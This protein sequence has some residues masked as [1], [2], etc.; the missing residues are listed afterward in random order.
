M[1]RLAMMA[2]LTVM[3]SA[4]T[5]QRPT[6]VLQAGLGD[7]HESWSAVSA[8]I[9]AQAQVFAYDRPGYGGRAPEQGPRDPCTIA[10]ELRQ[11]L[12]HSGL[13]PPYIL[14]GHSFGGLYQYVFAKL[15]PKDVAGILLVDPT[16]PDHWRRMQH[17]APATAA[18]MK[19]MRAVAFSDVMRAEFDDQARC[20]EHIDT[21]QPLTIPAR[22]LVRTQFGFMESTAFAKM[23]G[24]L[25]S[26]WQ[27]L[28]GVSAAQHVR[29]AGHYIHHDRPD[30]VVAALR[31]V[32]GEVRAHGNECV[33]TPSRSRSCSVGRKASRRVRSL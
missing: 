33:S 8:V 4:A 3:T 13:A 9:A 22:L 24:S 29:G 26:D 31:A 6:V 30:D 16:H 12:R 10:A 15:Y 7:G 1:P 27:R 11:A 28:L 25:A 20:L 17:D 21:Q 2:L 23:T 14:V 19:V 5:A 18:F 32:I